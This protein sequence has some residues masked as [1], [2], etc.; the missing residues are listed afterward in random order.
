MKITNTKS[1]TSIS[2]ITN[3]IFRISTPIPPNPSL[4]TG[5]TFN[6]FLI[7]DEKPLLFHTGPKKLFPLVYEAIETI[8]P[9]STLRYIGF[10]HFEADECGSLNEFLAKAPN[11]IPL[12]SMIAKMVSVDDMANRE[13]HGMSDEESLSLGDHKVRWLD[14]PHLPHG[15]ECGYL[16][17]ETTKTLFC[18]DLFTQAGSEHQ[19]LTEE[20]ILAPSEAMRAQMDYFSHT[21]NAEVLIAKLASTEP[22]ILACMH[23]S[24]WKGNGAQLLGSLALALAS[25]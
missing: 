7:V 24:S 23:G 20:D 17:E 18:G 22:N 5:F 25:N 2:E 21:K 4:P 11:A 19:P 14:T 8:I 3:G 12:C 16:F 15:W 10:S 13:A 1:N 9:V 6:Q